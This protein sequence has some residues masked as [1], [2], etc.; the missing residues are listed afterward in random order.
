[1]DATVTGTFRTRTQRN[2]DERVVFM[3]FMPLL[4]DLRARTLRAR[5]Y[6]TNA[7]IAAIAGPRLVTTKEYQR[8]VLVN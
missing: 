8:C 1:M 6:D 4:Y 3:F 2:L 5:L 7:V